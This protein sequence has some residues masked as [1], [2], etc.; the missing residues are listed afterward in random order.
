M[1]RRG[2]S[3]DTEM[4][5]YLDA[6]ILLLRPR[7]AG[8]H[9][10]D[11]SQGPAA[12]LLSVSSDQR[13]KVWT[14]RQASSNGHRTTSCLQL[15]LSTLVHTHVADC[16]SIHLAAPDSV[17]P[18]SRQLS[19]FVAGIGIHRLAIPIPGGSTSHAPA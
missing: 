7:E 2:S 13:V 1:R 15:S 11:E 14:V 10:A 8:V 17:L 4:S 3:D 5:F 6:G 19:V 12:V 18:A 16:T 9:D